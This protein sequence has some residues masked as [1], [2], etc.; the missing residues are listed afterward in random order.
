MK[1]IKKYRRIL[2]AIGML[3]LLAACG[4][5]NQAASSLPDSTSWIITRESPA[6]S[7]SPS[8]TAQPVV[9]TE[10][11]TETPAPTEMLQQDTGAETTIQP[12]QPQQPQQPQQPEQ[13][14]VV[15]QSTEIEEPPLVEKT[16]I[17]RSWLEGKIYGI[18]DTAGVSDEVKQK[19][20][21]FILTSDWFWDT[22]VDV[23]YQTEWFFENGAYGITLLVKVWNT[24]MQID[25]DNWC[26]FEVSTLFLSGDKVMDGLRSSPVEIG[27]DLSTL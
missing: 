7:E 2:A 26:D 18:E 1:R 12:E 4:E 13:T 10:M 23:P 27:T 5:T 14:P 17:D 8:S 16:D 3:L 22:C 6:P 25:G 9:V 15:S 20:V 19:F 24:D 11:P 21:E